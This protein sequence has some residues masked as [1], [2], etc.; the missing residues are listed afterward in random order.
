MRIS[1]DGRNEFR[2]SIGVQLH[3]PLTLLHVAL[4]P[5]Q[6]FRVPGIYQIHFQTPLFQNVVYRDPINSGGLHRDSSNPALLQPG[7]HRL[8]FGGGASEPPYRLAISAWRYCYVVRFV[9]DINATSVGMY[10]F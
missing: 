7:G 10:H 3:Q 4:A 2:K 5:G 8:E 6:I 9:A 1:C